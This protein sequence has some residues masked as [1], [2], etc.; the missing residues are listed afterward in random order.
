MKIKNNYNNTNDNNLHNNNNNNNNLHNN[1]NNN[2][3]SYNASATSNND[4]I[5]NGYPYNDNSHNYDINNNYLNKNN[6]INYTNSLFDDNH[7]SIDNIYSNNNNNNNL[8]NIEYLSKNTSN[9][10]KL[11]NSNHNNIYENDTINKQVNND[12]NINNTYKNNNDDQSNN[13][14]DLNRISINDNEKKI[15]NEPNSNNIYNNFDN[16]HNEEIIAVAQ[17]KGKNNSIKISPYTKEI[18]KKLIDNPVPI[19]TNAMKKNTIMKR[20]LNVN[21]LATTG[22]PDMIIDEGGT[23]VK[24]STEKEEG[25]E[26]K[27]N[28]DH[29][30]VTFNESIEIFEDSQ[31]P[32]NQT[33]TNNNT[34]KLE[35]LDLSYINQPNIRN[36]KKANKLNKINEILSSNKDD[37]PIN[38]KSYSKPEKH[39]KMMEDFNEFKIKDF[40][41]EVASTEVITK[42]VYLLDLF[43]KFR[44]EFTKALKLTEGKEKIKKNLNTSLINVMTIIS[45]HKVIKVKGTVDKKPAEI[46]L[47]SCASVNLITTTALKKFKINKNPIGR[48]SEKIFQVYSNNST[49]SDIYELKISIGNYTFIDYFRKIDKDDIFDILIG[50]DTLKRN[51]FDI[52]LVND[53]LYHIDENNNPIEL[54]S[55]F[56]DVSLSPS[57]STN[58]I[59][60]EENNMNKENNINNNS[61]EE[62]DEDSE[63]SWSDNDNNNDN[64]NI[65]FTYA[66][67]ELPN[68]NIN[69]FNVKLPFFNSVDID[70]ENNIKIKTNNNKNDDKID[71]YKINDHKINSKVTNNINPILHSKLP[72]KIDSDQNGNNKLNSNYKLV[73]RNIERKEY[74]NKTVDITTQLIP[75]LLLITNEVLHNENEVCTDDTISKLEMIHSIVKK[76]PENLKADVEKLFLNYIS[77]LALKTD[78]LGSSKLYPH[79]INLIPG[80]TPIKQRA[81]RISKVQADALKK[82]L[83]KLINNNLIVPSSSPWS[84]PVVLVP[85]KNGQVR[86]C[87]DY[88]KINNCT[89]KDAYALPLIDDILY[90]VSGDISILSTIDLFSGYHQIPMHSDDKDITCFTTIYGNFNFEV[91][92][93]GLCNA[94][95]TFQREMNRIFFDL[96]GVCVFIYIDDL[97]IYSPSLDQHIK[98]LEKVF[99]ILANNGLK[100]NFEKC[101]FFKEE[102]ELLGHTLSTKGIKPMNSKIKVIANWLPP[103]NLKQLRSFLGAIGYYRKFISH[104]AQIAKPLYDLT[105]KNVP[106]VWSTE[107]N[108]AFEFLKIRLINAPILSPP[109]FDKPFIVRSDA[110]KSGIGGV[111]LQ[112]DDDNIEKPLYY[113]SRTLSNSE[114]N[115]SIT[116]LEGLAAFYCVMKFKPFLTG[117]S[118]ETILYTDHKPLV[119]IFKNKEPSS[120][121]HVKWITEFSILKIKVLYEEGR[122]NV[123]ADALSRLHSNNEKYIIKNIKNDDKHIKNKN[124]RNNIKNYNKDV[125]NQVINNEIQNCEI[126]N[127]EEIRN[128]KNTK[129]NKIKELVDEI[130]IN[131]NNENYKMEYEEIKNNVNNINKF[132]KFNNKLHNNNSENN[133]VENKLNVNY[134][135][136]QTEENNK[137]SFNNNDNNNNNINHVNTNNN[138]ID[139]STE[140]LNDFYKKIINQKFV[141]IDGVQYYKDNNELRKVIF[142]DNEKW[143]LIS[144]AHC[145]GHEGNFKTYHRLKRNYYWIG[146]NKDIRLFIKS[147]HV[148]QLCKPQPPNVFTED[149][150]TPP[151]L[152]FTR[153]GLDLVGPLY[154]SFRGNKYII[155]LVDYLTKWVEAEAL[156][157]TESEDVIRFLNN[158]FS[159]HGI[160]EILITDNGPQFISDKTKAF[161]DLNDVYVHYI[162]TYHPASNGEVENRNREIV[163][164]IRILKSQFKELSKQNQ[165][166]DDIL[167]S[168]LWALR[169]TKN[170]VTKFSSFE[171]LYGRKDLQP[172]ELAINIDKRFPEESEEEYFVRKFINHHN[173]ISEA[174]KNIETANELW[175]DRRRQIKRL[176]SEFKPGDLVLVRNFNRRKLDPYYIGPLKIVK[177]QFNTVT[178]CDPYT[179]EI[180]ERNIHLKNVIPYI[181]NFLI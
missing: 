64:N 18:K 155:V 70:K 116:E 178:V 152:P 103:S 174:I 150:A 129:I 72:S 35:Y 181:S 154:E 143:E 21:K 6:K 13:E 46:F 55:L 105:K 122:R 11:N 85:K 87:V 131:S 162:S 5:N 139:D 170:E 69:N 27:E 52:N 57:E 144:K 20:K 32:T 29:K 34:N 15:N 97:V 31:P 78:D 115:Y 84:S 108:N 149:L 16:Y 138:D 60:D 168:A 132:N 73:D 93:F 8:N 26:F 165:E 101:D 79:R 48:I 61:S 94:P 111:L 136:F 41:K 156:A 113:E 133:G 14:I 2:N 30:N 56:Y 166:W 12:V 176:R 120:A 157:K 117:N 49:C 140:I 96:I 106:F 90:Y 33:I 107:S 54:A 65:L 1:N 110:S 17:K 119:Y 23:N 127:N 121:R 80:T 130:K 59:N 177:Q 7:T 135:V 169:T 128:K 83:I 91:M 172:F 124:K 66:K 53:T 158:I 45:Q 75:S 28:K 175:K 92:P 123:V 164:Y 76:L 63:T 67:S 109:N 38:V 71:N 36:V 147:C 145:L 77:V 134:M 141:L 43:P 142:N 39:I 22:T 104:F 99:L 74:K 9:G 44:S 112:L 163:K 4:V 19:I 171:L 3:N 148:C 68:I 126:K 88:R 160:P 40:I 102:V 167:P 173:W 62:N 179:N 82:E 125:F 24:L 25:K 50:I 153:V 146:M 180:A 114:I 95:A 42:L 151:G 86:M 137:H 10:Y 161:L 89:L 98:D 47:D 58:R 37:I 51:R 81:Y 118:F 159:R 100:V